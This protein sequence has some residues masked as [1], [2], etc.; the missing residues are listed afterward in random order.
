MPDQNG[1]FKRLERWVARAAAGATNNAVEWDADGDDVAAAL[2]NRL[3]RDGTSS[4]TA[5]IPFAGHSLTGIRAA[6]AAGEPME[7]TQTNGLIAAAGNSASNKIQNASFLVNQ[8]GLS[9]TISPAANAYAHDRWKGG[10]SGCSYTLGA[11]GADLQASITAGS[12]AQVI[13]GFDIDGATM[14]VSNAGTAQARLYPSGAAAPA[15]QACPF[16]VS[17]LVPGTAAILEWAPG[18][19]LKPQVETGTAAHGFARRQFTDDRVRCQ[20]YYE[21]IPFGVSQDSAYVSPVVT[22][23]FKVT[24]ITVPTIT[25]TNISTSTSS[26]GTRFVD[27][28]GFA[29]IFGQPGNAMNTS[30]TIIASCEP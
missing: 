11:I 17:N 13:A 26:L 18:T 5:D 30:G 28:D 12:L 8:R 21:R 7:F 24:K 6:A 16:T 9:G 3:T 15:F 27:V 14:T 1:V 2:N 23:S 19:V 29:V 10:A 25:F 4:P 22:Y 20:A